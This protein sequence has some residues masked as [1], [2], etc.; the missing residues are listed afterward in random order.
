M[1]IKIATLAVGFLLLVWLLMG[2]GSLFEDRR[3]DPN[4]E[5]SRL[6]QARRSAER[7]S[8]GAISGR[9][10]EVKRPQLTP[11][12]RDYIGECEAKGA[13]RVEKRLGQVWIEPSFWTGLDAQLK[14]GLAEKLAI[15]CLD[16]RTGDYLSVDIFDKQS[17]K[18]LA[19]FTSFS[20]FKAY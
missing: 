9:D 2:I 1:K 17:A 16:D 7:E 4:L 20:G 3:P 10:Q 18:K 12:I 5:R 19:S 13:I 15:Y 8:S 6:A 11:Q 14:E